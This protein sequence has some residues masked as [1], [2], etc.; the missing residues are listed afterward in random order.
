MTNLTI[1]NFT[2]ADLETLTNLQNAVVNCVCKTAYLPAQLAVLTKTQ[3]QL[4]EDITSENCL[5]AKLS[6]KI[7]AFAS[8]NDKKFITNFFVD[9]NFQNKNIGSE[10]LNEIVKLARKNNFPYIFALSTTNAKTFFEKHGFVS[11]KEKEVLINNICVVKEL[12]TLQLA[13]MDFIKTIY[14]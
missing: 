1:E 2:I 9:N 12:M 6:G 10:L 7:V 3:A 4:S 8:L 14:K 5:V 13:E 11:V